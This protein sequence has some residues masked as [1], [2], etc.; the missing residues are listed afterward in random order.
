VGTLDGDDGKEI[1][2]A[3]GFGDFDDRREASQSSA[4]HDDF[5]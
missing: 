5:G 3:A 1:D 4:Y 2:I